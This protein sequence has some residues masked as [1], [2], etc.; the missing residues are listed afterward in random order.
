MGYWNRFSGPIFNPISVPSINTLSHLQFYADFIHCLLNKS[1]GL[2]RYDI[3]FNL[4]KLIVREREFIFF[5]SFPLPPKLQTVFLSFFPPLII[6][7]P[8]FFSSSSSFSFFLLSFIFLY[9]ALLLP[10]HHP[11]PR[12]SSTTFDPTS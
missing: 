9:L 5:H 1:F 7:H 2:I 3:H 11:I 4:L 12:R 6:Q 8:A 10:F